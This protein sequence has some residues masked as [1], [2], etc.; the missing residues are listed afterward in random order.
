MQSDM[1]TSLAPTAPITEAG[2]YPLDLTGPN[3]HMLVREAGVG[4]LVIGPPAMGR[5]ADLHVAPDMPIDWR[6]FDRFATPAGAPWPRFIRY[7]G[8]D[9]GFFDWARARPIEDL[10][11]CPVLPADV[12][13]DAGQSNI[14]ELAI[15][16]DEPGGHLHLILPK[17]EIDDY[18]R[19]TVKGDLA[20]FSAEG[21]MPFALTLAPRPTQRRAAGSMQLPDMGAL[22]QV[23]RLT[24]HNGPMAQPISLH[25]LK[26]FPNLI[27]LNLW[28]GFTD[29]EA[30]ADQTRLEELEL[31]FMPDLHGLPGLDSWPNLDR[32]IA[33][34]VE[35]AAGK[36]LRQQLKARAATRPW[37]GHASVNQLRKPE[38]WAAEYGRPFSA[39]PKRLA[40]LAN[41]AYDLAL[42]ALANGHSLADAEAA[43]IAFTVRFNGLES[44]ETGERDDLGDAIWQLGR[45]D[46]AMRLGVT[47]DMAQ[48]WFDNARDY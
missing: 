20:R 17:R 19:L 38:W 7:T 27:S 16:L 3:S 41:E 33:F 18:G 25:C 43:L 42:A 35:E 31:R 15:E 30:L 40:K 14:G 8:G 37:T 12:V 36:R 24:L 28:G 9:M 39:W 1:S 5:K 32:L 21:D 44:I 46:H 47:E 6:I 23:A 34:N 10:A 26:R 4:G 29:L 13:V 22:Q 45:S 48:S 11:W 2:H